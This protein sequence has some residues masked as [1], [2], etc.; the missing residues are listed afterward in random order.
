M[1]KKKYDLITDL[2]A[3]AVKE[4]TASPENWLSFLR[5]ACRNFRL[6]FDDQILIYAQRPQASAVL[7]MKVWNEKFGRWV[8]RD[9]KGI[10]VFDKDSPKLRLKYYYDVSDT[11]EGRFR[12]LL[13]PVP[14]WEVPEEYQPDVRETLANAFGVDETV[15]GFAET[16]LEAAKIAAEDNLADYLPDLLAGRKGSYLE[17]VDEYNVE[18]EARQLLAASTAY[19]VMVRCGVDTDLYLD[20]EDFRNITDFNTPEMVNLFGV[21][22]SDV[23]EMALSE[24]S[25]TVHKLRKAERKKNRTFAGREAGRYNESENREQIT[26]R[27]VTH[28]SDHIQ[29][30]GRLSSSGSD[31][32]GRTGSTPWEVRFPPSYLSEKLPVWDVSEPADKRRTEPTSER[33]AERGTGEDGSSDRTDESSLGRDRGTESER[34][35]GV[36]TADEQHPAGSGR[37]RDERADL[38]LT[39]QEPQSEEERQEPTAEPQPTVAEQQTFLEELAGEESPAFSMPQEII[40]HALQMGSSFEHG[41]YRIYSYFLQGHSNKERADFL[42]Q[43][44]GIWGSGSDYLGEKFNRG[45]SAKG[46]FIKWKDYETT[47]KWTAVAK[48]IEELISVGRYMTEKELEYIPEYEKGVLARGIYNFFYH[49]PETFLRPY[50]YGSDYHRAIDQIRPQLDDPNRVKEILSMMEEVL[51]GTADYDQRY[52]SMQQAH[53]D[54]TDYRDGAFSLFT[55]IPAERENTQ[56]P[57]EPVPAQSREEVLAG[58]L[59]AFYQSYDWYE[60]QDTIEAGE[61]QEDVLR[62]LQEQLED[63]QSVQE[64][65]SYL[66][67]VR[68]GMDTE[69]ENYS[70]VSEL[71]AGIADL[72][73]M[74]PPYDLQVDT[75]VTIGTKEYSID[76][77]SDEMV[78]LRDQMYPLFTEEMPREV[79]DRRVRENPAN[80]HL[81]VYRKPSEEP[82]EKDKEE[83]APTQEMAQEQEDGFTGIKPEDNPFE[84]E[85][86]E[87]LEDL[88]PAWA[89]KKPAGRVRGFDLHPE[90]PQ[91]SRSQYRITDE[92]LGEGTAKEK[93]RA[94]LMAIQLLKKCEEENRFATPKEQEI[95]SGYVGWGGLSDAFDETKSSWSTEYLELKTVLTEE[96]YAAARQSTLTAFY[97]PPVVI[98]AM[99]QALENMGLKSGNI[100][101]PSCG[102]G[103]FIGRKPESL[104]DCKVYG[105]EIDSISARI[106]QQLYQKSTIAAQGFED[107][108]LPDSFF[109]VVI[110]NVPFGSYKVLDRKYDK[111]NF[112]IHDYFIAKSI[113][114]TRPKG[115]LALITSNGISGG[116]MDKRDDRV[117]RYIAQRC[118]LLGAIRLPNNAFL[119]NAGTEINTDILFFQKRETPRDLNV[120]LPDWVEVERLY[121]NDH[122]NEHG[123]SRHRVVSINPY[124]QHHPEM[125][126]GEQEIVSG[127]YGPQLICKP[128]P[129]RDLKELLEQAVENLEAEITDYEVEELVEEED[130]S[131]PADP[132]VANFSYTVY[133]GKIYYRE[134]S[135][136]KPVELSVT[137]QNRVKGM[138]AIRD[139]T[140]EL[141]AY[142]TEGDPDEEIE[143]QQKKLNHLYDLFQR[144]Y[145]L[146]NS[147]ANSMVFSDDSSYPLLCSLEIVAED[148]TLERKADMFTKRTIKPHETVTKVDTASEALSLSLSEKAC[149]DMEYLCSLTGKSAGEVEEEL[150][151]VI[152]R[153]PE[154]EGMDQPRFVSEDEYLSGNVRQKLREAKRAAEISEVYRSNVEALEKVQPKDLTASEISVR[155]GATWIPE[156]D[157]ADFMFELLQT[158]NYSQWKIKVHFSRHTGE[159]NIEGKS[160]DR[161]NPRVTNTYGTNRVNAYK[162]IEDTL[163]LRDTRVFDYVE[164]AEGKRKPILNRKETAIAQG[165]QDLIKQAFQE[166]IWKDP[167]RR[168]RLT[169]DYNERFNAIRPR[170]YDGSHLHFYGMNPEI[171]LRKHQKDGVARII[172]GGNT[173]LAYVVGAG[174]TYTMVAAAMECK[175]LG[176]CSKSMAV[177]PNHIIEQFAAE[178]LQLYPAANILVATKKDFEKKNRKKFCGRIATSDIDAVIIGH[179]QFEKIPLSV[180]R[181]ERMLKME[182][183]EI[184]EGIAEAKKIQGS[185]FTVKQMERAKKSLETRLKRLHDQSRKDDMIT[186]EE[187]GVD[188]LF[189][190]EADGYKN[191]YLTTKMRNVGGV[192]QTEAQKSSDMYMKCRYLDEITGGKGVIFST[193]TPVSNSMVE[194]YTMQRYLQ[195][196]TLAEKNLQHFDAWASTF[197]ETVT[198]LEIAPEGNGYRL[199][200]RFA[201]FYNLPELMQ[202]FR[203]VADIQTA[204]MLN[205]P[206]PEAEYRVVKVKPTELQEE[207]VEEL[208]NRAERVRNN[209]V[210]PR[211]DNMLKITND[212]RKLALDQRLS[213]PLLP[214]DPGSKVNACVEEIYRHWEDGKEKKLT[215]LVFCDLSTP[216]TDGTFSVYNDIRDKLLAKGIPPEEIAFIHDANT[217][218][219]KKELFSK[220]RR[221]AVRILMGS[222]FKMGAGTNVQDRI[223]A[224]HD[225]DCPWRP[226]D[227]EQRAGRTIRQGNQNPK[228]E[229]IR[230][231][232]EGTFDAYLYQTIENK[233]KYIS[234]IMTSKSPARSVEDIDEV[235]LS[236]AEIKA[237]ATGNPHIKEKM[238]LDI[239]VTRLQLLKQSFLNQKY[240]MEDQVAKHLP[241]RIREQ[242]T[243]ITQYE[244]DIAQVKA[245]TPLDRETFPVMQIGDHSYTEK[246][247]AGQAIIDACKAMKSPEPVLLGAYRGLSMELSYS[248]VGQE[249]V[250]ALHGKGTYK[251]PLGTDIYGNITR[252][253]NKMN[254]LPDNLSRCREQLET[255]KSQ[256]ETA[257]VEAQKEFPQEKELAEKVARL[258][259]LNVLLDMDKKDRVVMEEEPETEEIEPE[260]EKTAWVR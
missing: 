84:K 7:P 136:M 54:L 119:A 36:G 198:A 140:R 60:Y 250:I 241:A 231:V 58:R 40:D 209:E 69:D 195:Y 172:Y 207:M 104:S 227:L 122:V 127:P 76:F 194:L 114:K 71:I 156:S 246:K 170:E 96:E 99:Y 240:E 234:Q 13:R 181:Q 128:Y 184:I 161:G 133:D 62:Q 137:A 218:V 242:E 178:W 217:D 129:D 220:V 46:Y 205:L 166:W 74:N 135:R 30:T 18:V 85:P 236:Y 112:L 95:L 27:G 117:R 21:A 101:E 61:A 212:G 5:S 130:Y 11:Q 75:I 248:S 3:E 259:E 155:L 26:E 8:K 244:A 98:S 89:Q 145:G 79:F 167:K 92:H 49:Q 176:L 81:K 65:Y 257:K 197:G 177:V 91:E 17:E 106:A 224:S 247:E 174:K 203:E 1:A 159:W 183:D 192:A 223:I 109:D 87:V 226:R 38:Q 48:R 107:A 70:E 139:C 123:E 77:I 53:Q 10:A 175:R 57:P 221:G 160:M 219:R 214:D 229:I 211:E 142:Q 116:T 50:P 34:P 68:E 149:I 255:A 97:T 6:P 225:L 169:E 86:E 25:D 213:N 67:R 182:I 39:G 12:R 243:W 164:D 202:M 29:Q 143:G 151:G 191:L 150:K 254:E 55:P 59:N 73:A 179:S 216:K 239:Q 94:N 152:F 43:E 108:D 41:K 126:L 111:Y 134:N 2:Y 37:D 222:T 200:T 233:Q 19:M 100:L 64:I 32:A 146:L 157:I 66:I 163:N 47:L 56:A 51:A 28:E 206:V 102:T 125:V 208:G 24:I 238:D 189:V 16:I 144:K 9:S 147:R 14:L 230:Y 158:P 88:A 72:P 258:G 186:F 193:G 63:P 138:I 237:L 115:V 199:K 171:T 22:A 173:L 131:I 148:G 23:A 210:N 260:R 103:N 252:L 154:S 4:V 78:V 52:P 228:V 204:D 162:I 121:E 245:H 83:P 33:S 165:K 201:R 235:A 31:R 93:F 44:Y 253:D 232:T 190:D 35:D 113:D 45:T 20:T 82:A 141:I 90:I 120:D 196:G 187:L 251:V 168:Q 124:F 110:G 249:F 256:L 153:L 80:D 180:E 185:R 42:K 118:D 15:T 188:R 105:V 215:Q 132:S